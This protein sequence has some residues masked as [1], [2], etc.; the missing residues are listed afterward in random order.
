[1]ENLRR[2]LQTYLN[3]ST[4]FYLS[5][6]ISHHVAYTSLNLKLQVMLKVYS[7]ADNFWMRFPHHPN[8]FV[9]GYPQSI[10]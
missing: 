1:M 6:Y 8:N 10:N 3:N 2:V 4:P 7:D 5:L 9:R